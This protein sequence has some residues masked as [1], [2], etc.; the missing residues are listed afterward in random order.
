MTY[1]NIYELR[2][3]LL[4]NNLHF[5][6][7]F[8]EKIYKSSLQPEDFTILKEMYPYLELFLAIDFEVSYE[9]V[10]NL[11]VVMFY[12]KRLAQFKLACQNSN[13]IADKE[14]LELIS[15]QNIN[16][17]NTQKKNIYNQKKLILNSLRKANELLQ[18]D[19]TMELEN[20]SNVLKNDAIRNL[21]Y[22]PKI[23]NEEKLWRMEIFANWGNF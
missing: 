6:K 8:L 22:T 2:E 23:R 16:E 1:G 5:S 10:F 11:F 14:A 13:I 7:D 19:F 18:K 21:E 4:K 15:H 12:D 17:I 3:Y 20:D 9:D